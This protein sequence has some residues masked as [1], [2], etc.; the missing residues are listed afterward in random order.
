MK[1]LRILII[2]DEIAALAKMQIMLSPFGECE[3]ADCGKQA[4]DMIK[5]SVMN[6][7]Y[8]DLITIDIELPDINGIELLDM[9]KAYEKQF[10]A[11][12][13]K[14]IVS[15]SGTTENVINALARNCNDFLVKPVKKD[16]LKEKLLKWRL[17]R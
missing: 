8:Y 14:F 3:L 16:V 15:A 9:I 11:T 5:K 17:I 1:K 13:I 2:D 6:N 4:L 7:N 12:S 10:S